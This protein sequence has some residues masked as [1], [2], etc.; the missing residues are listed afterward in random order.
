MRLRQRTA[1][2]TMERMGTAKIA[3][4]GM[5]M[6]SL[7]GMGK[8]WHRRLWHRRLWYRRMED[9]CAAGYV[10]HPSTQS[11][12]PVKSFACSVEPK[13]TPIAVEIFL[14]AKTD[15]VLFVRKISVENAQNFTM[16]Y[17]GRIFAVYTAPVTITID[18]YARM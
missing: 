8:Q 10:V 16:V 12:P 7:E 18:L 2:A 3:L 1:T 15:P 4:E 13:A 17:V 11:M 14:V 5:A 9:R 6:P